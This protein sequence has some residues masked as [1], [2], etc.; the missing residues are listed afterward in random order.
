MTVANCQK[1]TKSGENSVLKSKLKFP[2][3]GSSSSSRISN[4]EF[5]RILQNFKFRI[6]ELKL[7]LK[8][9][10]LELDSGEFSSDFKFRVLELDFKFRILENSPAISNSEFWKILQDFKFRILELDFKFRILQRFQIQNSPEFSNS[11][12]WRISNSE[13][14]QD[15]GEFSRISNSKFWS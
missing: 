9:R 10:I 3:S 2:S 4:S 15:S 6:L 14:L 5:W 1:L 11:E 8:F 13:L 12:F 7:D